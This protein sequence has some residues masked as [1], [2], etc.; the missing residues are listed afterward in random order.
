MIADSAV[1]PDNVKAQVEGATIMAFTA[2]VK[3]EI[4]FSEGRAMQANFDSYQMLRMNEAPRVD[5][6]IYPSKEEPGGVGEPGIPPAAPALAN[7]IF[8]APVSASV[9]CRLI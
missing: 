8:A 5:V 2:A 4:T 9:S 3:D 1:N 6:H 7:A